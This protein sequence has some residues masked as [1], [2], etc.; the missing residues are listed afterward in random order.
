MPTDLYYPGVQT[1]E[2]A[3]QPGAVTGGAISTMGAFIGKSDQGPVEATLVRSW[4]E[5]ARYYGNHYTDLHNAVNDFYTNGGNQA[6]IVRIV[7]SGALVSSLKV[8]DDTITGAPP[9][10]TIP[11]FT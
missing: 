7:A 2:K 1:V 3:F 8:Y 11:L 9:V 5:F 6:A 4:A 10:Q